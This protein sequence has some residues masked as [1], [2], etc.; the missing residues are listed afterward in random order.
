MIGINDMGVLYGMFDK[1]GGLM[2]IVHDFFAFF[3]Q[4]FSPSFFTL[5]Y[6]DKHETSL[7]FLPKI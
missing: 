6:A 4:S 7:L 1:D 5:N 2:K 3:A